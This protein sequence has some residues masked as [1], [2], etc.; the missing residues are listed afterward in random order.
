VE[1]V[2][3]I[4]ALAAVGSAII[5]YFQARDA[6]A[7]AA[8][9]RTRDERRRADRVALAGLI[10]PGNALLEEVMAAKRPAGG[11]LLE[12]PAP[13]WARHDAWIGKLTPC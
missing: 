12:D 10:D 9:Q 4:A 6:K 11:I 5:A 13:W 8:E 3:W 2:G 7:A 1:L